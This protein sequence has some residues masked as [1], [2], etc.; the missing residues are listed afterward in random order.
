MCHT[1]SIL[2]TILLTNGGSESNRLSHEMH[3]QMNQTLKKSNYGRSHMRMGTSTVESSVAKELVL[4]CN[5][6]ALTLT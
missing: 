2:L 4:V 6:M 3:K 1:A 5:S